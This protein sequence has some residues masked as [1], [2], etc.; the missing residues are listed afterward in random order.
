MGKENVNYK[1]FED[2]VQRIICYSC[3]W[4]IA[5]TASGPHLIHCDALTE[6]HD[7][8]NDFS[9]MKAAFLRFACWDLNIFDRGRL[10]PQAA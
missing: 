9:K 1:L 10:V 3:H 8:E 6:K 4:K 5:R 2:R 7:S